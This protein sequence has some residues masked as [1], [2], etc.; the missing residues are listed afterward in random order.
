MTI[1]VSAV[2]FDAQGLVPVV[3][4]DMASGDVLLVAFMNAAALE[5]TL[6]TGEA[7]FW[8]RSRGALWHKGE[9]S[10]HTLSVAQVL[11]NCEVNS[12]LLRVHLNGP[13]ACHDG[14]RSC[15]YRQLAVDGTLTTIATRTFDPAAV[16]EVTEASPPNPLSIR[17]GEGE[18]TRELQ[19]LYAGY[20]RLRDEDYVAISSTSRLLHDPAVTP[21]EL[22]GRAREELGE[23]QG[24]IDGTHR[25]SGTRD[26]ILLEASQV[27][28]WLC[29][30]AAR[31]SL[32][33]A[34][35]Q[36]DVVLSRSHPPTPSP[37]LRME[38]GRL[39]EDA[40]GSALTDILLQV[41]SL[42]AATD[43]API[44]PVR[45]DLASLRQ[46]LHAAAD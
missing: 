12:L 4:Q 35:W 22:L 21:A 32:T 33:Y 28:Y 20:L 25:H 18:L 17:N 19:A 38:R 6:S 3:A 8:S 1:D 40:V 26:D 34:D 29:L 30:A 9:S 44:E 45:R 37:F 36:P 24:V 5:Q 41:A 43:V 23:L 16:Y 2:Q 15:Y 46:R 27:I 10:G 31:D 11:L 7:Y 14:Y 42:L 39:H 13:G